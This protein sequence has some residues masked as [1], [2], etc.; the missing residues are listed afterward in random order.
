[1]YLGRKSG[2]VSRVYVTNVPKI[3]EDVLDYNMHQRFT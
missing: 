1:M 3:A 2:C